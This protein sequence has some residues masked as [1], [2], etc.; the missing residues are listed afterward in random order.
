VEVA[1]CHLQTVSNLPAFQQEA[2]EDDD[3]STSRRSIIH[4]HSVSPCSEVGIGCSK[5]DTILRIGLRCTL[6]ASTSVACHLPELSEGVVISL[7][8]R[9]DVRPAWHG[10]NEV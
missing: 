3:A 1:S 2:E 10:K 5:D 9:S 4:L 7:F 6:L 8:I